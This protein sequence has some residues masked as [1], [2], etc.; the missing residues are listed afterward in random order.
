ML[1]EYLLLLQELKASIVNVT[2]LA[3]KL[4]QAKVYQIK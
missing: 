2:E 1:A 4:S 3:V